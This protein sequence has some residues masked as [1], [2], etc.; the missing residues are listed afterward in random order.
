MR[1]FVETPMDLFENGVKR[2]PGKLYAPPMRGTDVPKILNLGS[3]NAPMRPDWKEAKYLEPGVESN[4]FEVIDLDRP[5]WEA[6]FLDY[7]EAS[8]AAVHMYHFL[9]HLDV[10]TVRQQLLEVERVLMYMGV[11]N[12]VVPHA[13]S[14]LAFQAPD[15]RS[16]WT[17]E[18]WQDMF[19]SA[20]Y[21]SAYGHQWEMDISFMMVGGVRWSNLCVML[22][23]VKTCGEEFDTP[24]RRS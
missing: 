17:E 2:D 22:Q 15:H 1:A 9:E 21:D 12:I 11:A 13:M 18:G 14:P 20:G 7:P 19:Y 3:G 5:Q 6:P 16:F 23:L 24:W 8:C 10:D 4:L